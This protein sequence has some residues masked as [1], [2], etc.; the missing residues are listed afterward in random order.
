M[1]AAERDADVLRL[2]DA[3]EALASLD[4][5]KARVVELRFFGGLTADET[6]DSRRDTE[7]RAP[8]LE[9]R[10]GLAAADDG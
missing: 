8:R 2:E 3:L 1:L 5:R 6:G 9:L 7:D 4:E 10:E